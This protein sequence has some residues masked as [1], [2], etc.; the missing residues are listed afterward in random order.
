[1]I[2]VA[3]IGVL[4]TVM[5]QFYQQVRRFFFLNNVR[6][7]LQRDARNV[8]SLVTK[9]MRQAQSSS[10]VIDQL[11]AQPPYSRI[12]FRD[13]T[14]DYIVYYQQG[15]N[16]YMVDVST[17]VISDDLRYLAFALPRSDDLGIIS[18]SFTLE[19]SIY[20]GKTKALHMASERVRIMN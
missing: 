17:R 13:I 1:M 16:L 6:T 11:T 5:P 3:I 4:F 12:S 7:E 15:K 19:K 10:I 20:E 9:R 14:G 18:V 8:M 2:V